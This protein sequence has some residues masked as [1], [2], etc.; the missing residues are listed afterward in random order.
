MSA[1]HGTDLTQEERT[2]IMSSRSISLST[3]QAL[4]TG[5]L[6]LATTTTAVVTAVVL[7][8]VPA[9]PAAAT[10]EQAPA[11]P[12]VTEAGRK[13]G[14]APTDVVIQAAGNSWTALQQAG[15]RWAGLFDSDEAGAEIVYEAGS[16]WKITQP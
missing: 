13:W 16:A 12:A 5:A 2:P 9:R 8:E 7:D 1:Q 11:S 3:R 14:S 15:S 4:I 6:A 10:V